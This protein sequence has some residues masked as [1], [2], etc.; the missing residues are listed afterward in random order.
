MI[1][2]GVIG[3]AG[4]TGS[5]LVRLLFH[6]PDV[7]I[8]FLQSSSQAGKEV[9]EVIPG[10]YG[11]IGKFDQDINLEA[12]VI[13][14]CR[15]HGRAKE[16]LEKTPI[17]PGVKIIDLSTDFRQKGDH[18]FI[19]GLPEL[20]KSLL[21]NAT[22]I[23]NPGCF[24]TA[25]QLALLP[26]AKKAQ[27]LTPVHV[28]AITGSTGAGQSPSPTTHFSWRDNNISL[29]K[30]LRHQHLLE[31]NQSLKQLCPISVPPLFFVPMRGNFSR[32]IFASI[33]MPSDLSEDEVISIF[34][35]YY[36]DAPFV[37]ISEKDVDLKMVVNSN[38]CLIKI[39]KIDGMIHVSS[40]IDNLLKGASGQAVQNMNIAFGLDE[41]AGLNLKPTV[42]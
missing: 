19:Y 31:I 12:D 14:L 27:L 37:Y 35:D 36:Q 15:G 8:H 13:F 3:A 6:H 9:S 34:R 1:K 30:I 28:H 42:Y 5:E 4:Y 26:F 21:R 17:R 40:V 38:Y 2:A 18:P 33:Y 24:A 11:F 7:K 10:V 16:F 23:A 29:Y 25:I 32:G 22:H 20:N 39:Q 41:K